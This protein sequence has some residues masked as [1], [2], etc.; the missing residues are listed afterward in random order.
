MRRPQ[1]GLCTQ[2]SFH[3]TVVKLDLDTL[4]LCGLPRPFDIPLDAHLH[5]QPLRLLGVWCPP[6]S[7]PAPPPSGDPLWDVEMWSERQCAEGAPSRCGP[8][9]TEHGCSAGAEARPIRDEC[10][11]KPSQAWAIPDSDLF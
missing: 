9:F 1:K 8:A 7:S 5:G 3:F 6:S 11:C 10:D 4:R 2:Y